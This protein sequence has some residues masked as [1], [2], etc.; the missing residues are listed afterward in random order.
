MRKNQAKVVEKVRMMIAGQTQEKEVSPKDT[1]A[2]FRVDLKKG[3]A[4]L[5]SALLGA[6][7][8]GIAYFVTIEINE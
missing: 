3:P 7:L 1:Y 4:T 8:N 2:S 5:D 6:G